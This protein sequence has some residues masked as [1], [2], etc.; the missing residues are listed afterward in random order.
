MS[1][2]SMRSPA[3]FPDLSAMVAHAVSTRLPCS[4]PAS[5]NE[6]S[7]Q[8]TVTGAA[9]LPPASTQLMERSTMETL[10]E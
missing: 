1:K 10:M 7:V 9:R 5:E 3:F 2:E 8:D 6:P 4:Q